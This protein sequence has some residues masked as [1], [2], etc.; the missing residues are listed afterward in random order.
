MRR[1]IAHCHVFVEHFRQ[2]LV[3]QRMVPG[4]AV[5]VNRARVVN[6]VQHPVN[7]GPMEPHGPVS[8]S[9]FPFRTA[10][11]LLFAIQSRLGAIVQRKVR[12][13]DCHSFESNR[14]IVR[15]PSTRIIHSSSIF[16]PV[17]IV[18][19]VASELVDHRLNIQR[20]LLNAKFSK[21]ENVEHDFLSLW[22]N[23]NW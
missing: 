17:F 7:S 4:G 6:E 11:L 9:C 13:L 19:C 20:I 21:F 15:E 3:E 23:I 22:R 16:L 14:R 10:A 1:S 12:H 2:R 8:T 5:G 18:L